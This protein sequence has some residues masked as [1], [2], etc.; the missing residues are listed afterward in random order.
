MTTV[1]SGAQPG[2]VQAT[3]ATEIAAS[4]ARPKRSRV[5]CSTRST[6][7]R[8]SGAFLTEANTAS[9][10]QKRR[11]VRKCAD[12]A[13]RPLPP[14]RR[15]GM[16]GDAFALADDAQ[17]LVQEARPGRKLRAARDP[18]REPRRGPARAPRPGIRGLP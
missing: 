17:L 11:C 15:H 7:W 16:A 10:Y 2:S 3:S 14:R 1:S 6:A 13:L 4:F 18:A 9:A 5:H 8:R 12:G